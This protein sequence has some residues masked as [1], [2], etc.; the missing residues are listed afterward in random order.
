MGTFRTLRFL[1]KEL[2]GSPCKLAHCLGRDHEQVRAPLPRHWCDLAWMDGRGAIVVRMAALPWLLPPRR[3]GRDPQ[4]SP[5]QVFKSG[6]P[7]Q[8]RLCPVIL[9]QMHRPCSSA[10]DRTVSHDGTRWPLA[11][12]DKHGYT[13]LRLHPP[14][15]DPAICAQL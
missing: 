3:S 5:I 14:P 7:C 9:E 13:A 12:A 10:H 15:P 6:A 4:T 8:P 1:E 11:C 2:S